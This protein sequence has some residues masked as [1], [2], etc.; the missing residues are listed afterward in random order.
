M[1]LKMPSNYFYPSFSSRVHFQL[2]LFKKL[3]RGSR[4]NSIFTFFFYIISCK[5][6]DLDIDFYSPPQKSH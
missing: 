6:S 2:K 4:R 5:A 3:A 1:T